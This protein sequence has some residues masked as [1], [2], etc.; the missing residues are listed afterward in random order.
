[1]LVVEDDD[2]S[3][4]IFTQSLEHLGYRVFSARN[5][6]RG[7]AAAQRHKPDAIL[8]DVA[9]PGM[10]G[11]EA[12]R[13]LKADPRTRECFVIVATAHGS[14]MFD[15]ARSAGC[16]AYFCKPF[17]AFA[18]DTVLRTL[19]KAPPRT[20]GPIVKRC[21]CGLDYTRDDW[22]A[23][24]LCGRVHVPRS[25]TTIELRNCSCGSSIGVA[26]AE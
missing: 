25:S 8:M 20:R 12:T 4:T 17:N 26:I 3:R 18:L 1:V 7:I 2:D 16:D 6:E 14:T 13:R 19:R 11:I 24:R 9:M 22:L 15:E 10:G 23:L 21:S 5:G